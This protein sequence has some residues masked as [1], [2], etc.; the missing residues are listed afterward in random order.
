MSDC[1]PK[2]VTHICCYNAQCDK[3]RCSDSVVTVSNS[4]DE[5]GHILYPQDLQCKSIKIKIESEAQSI[6]SVT[7][8]VIGF[9]FTVC[10]SDYLEYMH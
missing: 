1:G 10:F 4:S 3:Q 6:K 8:I 5:K 9:L 7:Y 2:L